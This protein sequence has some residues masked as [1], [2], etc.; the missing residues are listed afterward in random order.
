MWHP[1]K[2]EIIQVI[3]PA[4]VIVNAL[5][6]YQSQKNYIK[7]K[8]MAYIT[9]G[10]TGPFFLAMGILLT[11]KMLKSYLPVTEIS[12]TSENKLHD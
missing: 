10:F 2:K 9:D 12:T 4:S 11:Y 3:H 6:S 1:Q 8:V 7:F 5:L